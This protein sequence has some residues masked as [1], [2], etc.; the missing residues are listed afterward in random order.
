MVGNQFVVLSKVVTLIVKFCSFS[1][2]SEKTTMKGIV[3]P[4]FTP[5]LELRLP[6]SVNKILLMSEM[7]PVLS[8]SSEIIFPQYAVFVFASVLPFVINVPKILI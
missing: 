3:A 1:G 5:T 2:R 6:A 4:G 8:I 7:F